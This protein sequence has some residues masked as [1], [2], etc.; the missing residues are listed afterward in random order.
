MASLR[1]QVRLAFSRRIVRIALRTSLVVGT[2]LNVVNHGE[3]LIGIVGPAHV[4]KV[5]LN[6]LVPYMVATYSAVAAASD[7]GQAER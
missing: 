3:V 1:K 5:L 4:P 2:V 7:R 6:Y